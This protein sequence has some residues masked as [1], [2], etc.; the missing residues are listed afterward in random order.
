V[1]TV[2][3]EAGTAG[4]I[5]EQMR[6]V[7]PPGQRRLDAGTVDRL[8]EL[9]KQLVVVNGET[10]AAEHRRFLGIKRRSLAVPEA[11]LASRLKDARVLVTGG[12]G[13]IG[14]AL[15]T[16]LWQRGPRR[17]ISVSR[18]ITAGWP[19][20]E[21]ADYLTADIRDEQALTSI[22]RM[23]EPD[24]IFHLAAQR[25]PG[26]AEIEVHRTITTNV[27]GTRN[28]LAAAT[29]HDTGQVVYAS[30]GK[31]LRPY[32]PEI[33][34]ASKRVGEWLMAEAAQSTAIRCSAARFTHVMDNSIIYRRL[35]AWAGPAEQEDAHGNQ[36][37]RL[38]QPDIYFYAQSALEAAQLLLCA[39]A[40]ATPGELRLQGIT[41]LGLPFTPLDLAVGVLGSTKSSTP[42]Y[43][44]G[45]DAG[46]ERVAF[47]ALYDPLTAGD[48]SPLLS[49]LEAAATT[50]SPSAMTDSFRLSFAPGQRLAKQLAALVE[51]CGD[52]LGESQLKDR[53]DQLSWSLLDS[54]LRSAPRWV[55]ERCAAQ[56]R[57]HWD[58]MI[59]SHR[60]MLRS[61][62]DLLAIPEA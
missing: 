24:V 44:S 23:T 35:L 31:A 33:Y 42:I 4:Y 34:A 11:L 30:T 27:L 12:T 43:F 22:I 20:V 14:S 15:M 3:P 51:D 1:P 19:R 38:H 57:R 52:A 45:Y 60:R 58:T 59:P 40:G 13:C 46:Y 17:L 26:L 39:Y 62:D 53:L 48:V 56:A 36:V 61:I 6:H 16:Q 37:V 41:D 32:L 28:V 18:G 29:A 2:I 7:A 5:I 50:D 21:T 54:S 55:L 25:D 47:P 8:R 10:S 9:T 49:A